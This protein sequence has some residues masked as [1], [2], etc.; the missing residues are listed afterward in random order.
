M[1][2]LFIL[3]FLFITQF[4][5]CW[6][7][8]QFLVSFVYILSSIKNFQ[9]FA[10]TGQLESLQRSP[11]PLVVILI[12]LVNPLLLPSP[13]PVPP[14][15][16]SDP[17]RQPYIVTIVFVILDLYRHVAVRVYFCVC[18]FVEWNEQEREERVICFRSLKSQG[19]I[20]LIEKC[21]SRKCYCDSTE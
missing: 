2:R 5:S 8:L 1:F 12:S 17:S 3:V 4:F 18:V 6:N 7:W 16:L 13:S 14:P 15:A 20:E 9:A 19:L 11:R 21:N 10:P